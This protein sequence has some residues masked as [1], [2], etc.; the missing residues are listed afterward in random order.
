MVTVID[1][2]ERDGLAALGIDIGKGTFHVALRRAEKTVP[3]SFSNE[4]AGF[5]KLRVWLDSQGVQGVHACMEA[6]GAYWESL[7]EF[8]HE[9]GYRV[10]VVNPARIAFYARSE[11]G[12]NK[13][14]SADAKVIARFCETQRL[15]VWEPLPKPVR[16]LQD[17]VR[18]L[19]ALIADRTRYTLR[20]ETVRDPGVK[21]RIR[22][23]LKQ[24]DKEIK[25]LRKQIREQIQEDPELQR[26]RELL[27]SIP[28][29]G[30]KT[31]AVILAEFAIL[32]RL[33]DCRQAAAFVGV[34]PSQCQSGRSKGHTRLSKVGNARLRKA[35]FMPTLSAIRCNP[36]IK[37]FY[38]HLV[39]DE[40]K[41]RMVAVG[42]AEHKLVRIIYGVLKHGKPF[43]PNHGKAA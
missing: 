34:T 43:D 22:G 25:T 12:R 24:F 2:R 6:T 39:Q 18:Y 5:A 10:S 3:G 20:L 19:D 33:S 26:K 32:D 13:T 36:I 27:L 29:I 11:L 30:E 4:A 37:E 42:A 40:G 8:L 9:A 41:Q 15:H 1:S 7:A 31:V 17:W 28:G 16:R 21:K 35:L 14:D 23:K 38:D